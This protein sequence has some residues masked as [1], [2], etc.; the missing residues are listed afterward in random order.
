[1]GHIN[2]T[3]DDL[4]RAGNI[5][6]AKV[7]NDPRWVK[8]IYRAL[9]HLAAGQFMYDGHVVTLKSASSDLV[10][11]IN[12]TEPMHCTCKGRSKG[13]TCWHIAAARLIVR[14]AELHHETE[15]RGVWYKGF[16]YTPEQIVQAEQARRAAGYIPADVQ[17]KADEMFA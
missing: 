5:A 11:R 7:G 9:E 3:R 1:M 4:N 15:A 10:Y 17:A 6:L 8:I 12:V 2:F 16:Y 13:Y 14:A